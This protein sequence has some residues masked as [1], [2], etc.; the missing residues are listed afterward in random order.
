M[1]HVH[2]NGDKRGKKIGKQHNVDP[3]AREQTRETV[4]RQFVFVKT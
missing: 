2:C 3:Y 1:L 4:D